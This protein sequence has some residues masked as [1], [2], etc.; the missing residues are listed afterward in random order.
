LIIYPD[1]NMFSNQS[2]L[3]VIIIIVLL[4]LRERRVNKWKLMI[5][6]AFMLLITAFLVQSVI[7]TNLLNFITISVGFGIGIL[8]GIAVGSFMEVKIDG[9]GAMILKGSMIAVGLWISV[10]LLKIYGQGV[11]NNTG[12]FNIGVLSS[13]ILML[14]LGAMISR[15]IMVYNKYRNFKK[16][17]EN[18]S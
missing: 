3:V 5:L 7:F 15:R 18:E 4:Q 1:S 13:A 17:S 11:L 8:V 9:D 2:F 14:T 12:Y 10:I 16:M 6:P